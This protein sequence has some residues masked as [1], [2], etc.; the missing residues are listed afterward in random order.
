M[1]QTD[2]QKEGLFRS[3]FTAHIIV[4][5]HILILAGVGLMVVLFKG[6]YLYLPWIMGGIGIFILL[7][8]W[9]IYRQV[10]SG[11]SDI[12]QI[13]SMPQFKDRN[14]EIKIIGGLATL[15]M[16]PASKNDVIQLENRETNNAMLLEEKSRRTEDKLAMLLQLYE[17]KLIS[18]KDFERA[19]QE[20]IH[21]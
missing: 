15:K 13:L 21:G 14:V 3:I 17:K 18:E 5:L 1:K 4:L 9:F 6:V 11:S 7:T 8:A 12:H 19:K 10:R 16:G 2:N 20:I